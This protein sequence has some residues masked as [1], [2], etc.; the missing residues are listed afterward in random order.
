MDVDH[1]TFTFKCLDC[2]G[3]VLELPD[4]ATDD[5]IAVCK[6]CRRSHGRYGDIKVKAMELA[7]AESRKIAKPY[8]DRMRR[9]LTG[10]R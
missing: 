5:S 10:R 1:I 6:S 2:G 7:K 3:T 8:F 4:N 9:S